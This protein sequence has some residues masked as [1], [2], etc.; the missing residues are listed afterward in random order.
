MND[1]KS[2]SDVPK[3]WET[4]RTGR[5]MWEENIIMQHRK[6]KEIGN[7]KQCFQYALIRLPEELKR[8]AQNF[9]ELIKVNFQA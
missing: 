1:L 3:V 4:K 2:R 5:R 9:P 6:T 7:M 8:K